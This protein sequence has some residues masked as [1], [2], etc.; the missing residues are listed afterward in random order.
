MRIVFMGTPDFAVPVLDA[1]HRHPDHEVLAVVTVP[2]Q[3]GGRNRSRRL[4]SAVKKYA[5]KENLPVLQ[6]EKLNQSRFLNEIRALQPDC[7]IVVAFKKLPR[8]VW[9]IPQYGT[10]NLHASLLP[11]YRG[12]APIN[13]AII[14]GE[15]ETGMTTFYIDENIDTGK[16]LLQSRMPVHHDDTAGSLYTRMMES[17]G[18]LVLKTLKGIADGTLQPLPQ[19]DRKASNAPKVFFD[20]NEID[21]NQDTVTLYNFIRGMSPYPAA[22]T[23]FEGKILKIF[24]AKPVEEVHSFSPGKMDTDYK[25]YFRIYT[26]DGYLEITDLQLEGKRRM[27]TVDF[28]N[29]LQPGG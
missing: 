23:Y 27:N 18:E 2:D 19:E 3:M 9:S 4:E 8:L 20:Q 14:R 24:F 21:F 15:K 16:I 12:A 6:P 11:A 25:N 26:K 28:L 5:V 22:W 10:I 17:S 1:L 7:I 29:G 13:H